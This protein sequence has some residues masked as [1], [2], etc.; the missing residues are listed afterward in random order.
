MTAL[1]FS[2]SV[3]LGMALAA[4]ASAQVEHSDRKMHGLFGGS[5]RDPESR[6]SLDLSLSAYGAYDDDILADQR[7]TLDPRDRLSGLFTGMDGGMSYGR[8]GRNI[9][10]GLSAGANARY[11]A[12]SHQFIFLGEQAGAGVTF[13]RQKTRLT[14]SGSG[15]YSPYFSLAP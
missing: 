1:K 14:M 4:P 9:D 7:L 3:V 5:S 13:H 10:F 11:F 6:Q 2:L 12:D 8:G 15:S